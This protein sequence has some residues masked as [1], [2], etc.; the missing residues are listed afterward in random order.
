MKNIWTQRFLYSENNS[1]RTGDVAFLFFQQ[2]LIH[3]ER[4]RF[5]VS[6]DSAII[7]QTQC[8]KPAGKKLGNFL[9]GNQNKGKDCGK[10]ADQCKR[11]MVTVLYEV[12]EWGW[13]QMKQSCLCARGSG[14]I[15]I[16]K[17]RG[18]I[19]KYQIR[20]ELKNSWWSRKRMECK[21]CP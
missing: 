1:A 12:G 9:S 14:S 10:R 20:Q 16:E 17:I 21:F 19:K 4:D 8:K 3:Y 6:H 11:K 2:S 18:V 15:L 13:L 7:N 5:I